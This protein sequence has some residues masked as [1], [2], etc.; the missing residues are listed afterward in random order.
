M[1]I[2]SARTSHSADIRGRQNRYLFSMA[3]RTLCVVLAVV[4]AGY[5]RWAFIAGAVFLPYIAVVAA[6]AGA[7]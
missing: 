7:V 3:V 4:T 2:T 6:N 5:L 1:H